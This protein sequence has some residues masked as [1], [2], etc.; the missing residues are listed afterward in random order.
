MPLAPSL[1]VSAPSYYFV[2]GTS[3]AHAFYRATKLATAGAFKR[4]N[5]NFPAAISPIM[6]PLPVIIVFIQCP[7]C[8]QGL[9]VL[10]YDIRQLYRPCT[11]YIINICNALPSPWIKTNT[12]V[13]IPDY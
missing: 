6:S 3:M 11:I 10:S 7:P 8:E 13:F 1:G 9:P 12:L 2:K 5:W 4:L